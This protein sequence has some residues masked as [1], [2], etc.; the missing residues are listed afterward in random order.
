M[1]AVRLGVQPNPAV[2]LMRRVAL[3][4]IIVAVAAFLVTA[5]VRVVLQRQAVVE[6]SASLRQGQRI[7]AAD[8]RVTYVADPAS[9]LPAADLGSLVGQYAITQLND[10]SLVTRADVSPQPIPIPLWC[11]EHHTGV[12]GGP[13]VTYSCFKPSN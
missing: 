9:A 1:S 11:D 8:L 12:N 10:G 3:E 6:L 4:V 5:M 2:H 7:T 13:V